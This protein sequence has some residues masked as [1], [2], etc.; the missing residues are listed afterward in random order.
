MLHAHKYVYSECMVCTGRGGCHGMGPQ[1]PGIVGGGPW[2]HAQLLT[3]P[4]PHVGAPHSIHTSLSMCTSHLCV[5][6][7]D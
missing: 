3:L 7:R 2:H 6:P 5:L 1:E 4:D